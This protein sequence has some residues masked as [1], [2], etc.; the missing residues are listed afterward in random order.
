MR[1]WTRLALGMLLPVATGFLTLGYRIG[2]DLRPIHRIATEEPLVDTSRILAAVAAECWDAAHPRQGLALLGRAMDRAAAERFEATIAHFTKSC[3]DACVYVTDDAGVVIF[4][5]RGGRDVGQSYARRNDVWLTLA[6]GYGARTSHDVP[7]DPAPSLMYVAAPVIRDG[8][9]VGVLTVGKP[10]RSVNAL[11][12]ATRQRYLVA[13]SVTGIAVLLACFWFARRAVEPVERLTRHARAVRDG[14]PATLP[15]LS[16]RE[17]RDLGAAFE[18]MRDALEGRKYVES[19]VQTLTHELKSPLA[20]IRGAAELLG[21]DPPP[22]QRERFLANVRGEVERITS[23]VDRLLLLSSVEARKEPLARTRVDVCALAREV[24]ASLEPVSVSRGLEVRL[25]LPER[26][27]VLAEAFLLR[28]AISNLLANAIEF[29]PAGG[30]VEVAVVA[31]GARV[32]LSVEDSGPGVPDY[33]LPRVF[34]RF[35]SLERPG[36]GRKGSGLGLSLVRE[37][38]DRHQGGATLANRDPGGARAVLWLPA[39]QSGA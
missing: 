33:A 3:V 19:Y 6:G 38:A 13:G 35:Y 14:R 22:A 1:L 23:L 21:E 5:S 31:G 8:R 10:T 36:T 28:H 4:D 18:E 32:E 20:A 2:Q 34:E 11:V 30:A 15:P 24:V 17:M 26:A 37:V 7:G 16:V 39:G 27:E 25:H 29:S 12:A 9:R